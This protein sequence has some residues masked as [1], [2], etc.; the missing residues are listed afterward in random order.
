MLCSIACCPSKLAY[1]IFLP[2][3]LYFYPKLSQAHV[4]PCATCST[5]QG[6]SP[7]YCSHILAAHTLLSTPGHFVLSGIWQLPAWSMVQCT[8]LTEE[9]AN[10]LKVKGLHGEVVP[11]KLLAH[12]DS[13]SVGS[14]A[15]GV[16]QGQQ[17]LLCRRSSSS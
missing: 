5:P 2:T 14:A 3:N 6:A 4:V 8:Y 13:H 16:A 10:Q 7:S 1:I 15:G 17:L 11:P 9:P 12:A